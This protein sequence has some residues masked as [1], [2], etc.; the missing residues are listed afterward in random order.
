MER[1]KPWF[2]LRPKHFVPTLP[3]VVEPRTGLSMGQSCEQMVT[4][5]QIAR[6]AQDQ[7]AFESHLH[8]A[9]AYDAGFYKDLIVEYQG[10]KMDNNLRRDTS[11]EK[12]AKLKLPS[13][14][15]VRYNTHCRQFDAHDDGA[16]AVLLA[17]EEWARDRKLPILA[18]TS[19]TAKVAAVDF[20][21]KKDC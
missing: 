7:L 11:I 15:A 13:I 2:G 18:R 10:L 21:D 1:I 12:L 3:G 17:T 6:Q 8:A 4:V 14:G 19:P 9:A 16:A 5:W 20:V